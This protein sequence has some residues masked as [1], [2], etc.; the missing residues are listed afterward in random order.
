MKSVEDL[1]FSNWCTNWRSKLTRQPKRFREKNCSVWEIKRGVPPLSAPH[2]DVLR[3]IKTCKSPLRLVNPLNDLNGAQPLNVLN[4][5]GGR[6]LGVDGREDNVRWKGRHRK[7]KPS[8][9]F[10]LKAT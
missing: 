6:D 3:I 2:F 10:T 1:A 5:G 9:A 7:K 4:W 8:V